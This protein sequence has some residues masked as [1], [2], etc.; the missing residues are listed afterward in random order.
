MF[1]GENAVTYGAPVIEEISKTGLALFLGGNILFSHI[2]FGMVE[3][4]YDIIK[5]RGMLS[6]TAGVT[7]FISHAAFGIITVYAWRFFYGP[8]SGIVVAIIIHM[9]WNYIIIH[10][11]I[12]NN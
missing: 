2:I 9:L 3:A 11:K 7:G 4:L 6:Y 10:I 8:L 12:K 5:N 1:I